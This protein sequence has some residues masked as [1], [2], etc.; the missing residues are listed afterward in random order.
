VDA[1][2]EADAVADS[3]TGSKKKK[4]KSKNYTVPKYIM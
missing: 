3:I 4:L 1:L 2:A